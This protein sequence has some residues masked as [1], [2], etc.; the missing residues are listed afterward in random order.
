MKE[1]DEILAKTDGGLDIFVH[2]LGKECLRK[3]FRSH[4]RADDKRPSCKLYRNQALDGR[5][6]YY[7]HD[8]GDS[9]FSGDC[10]FVASQILN[11]NP[12]TDFVHLLKT[13]DQDMCLGVFDQQ[14]NRNAVR[15]ASP[16][17]SRKRLDEEKRQPHSVIAYQAQVKE[18]S[19]EELAYWSS[20]GITE[21]TLDRFQV[22]SLKSCHFTKVDGRQYDIYSTTLTPSYG[23][24][25]QEGR[26]IKVYRPHSENRFLYAGELPSPYIF[27]WDQLPRLGNMLLVTG[28]EKDVLSLSSHGFSAICFNSETAKI[29]YW[30]MDQLVKR[31]RQIVFV[32]DVDA[33]GRRESAQRVEELHGRYPVSRIDL[34]LAGSKQEKD[35]SDYFLLGGTSDSLKTLIQQT[36]NNNKR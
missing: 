1:K 4:M 15:Q 10:F 11:I 14:T 21:D 8:F 12:S 27:G 13:I 29:P 24:F 9:R 35:V 33:T 32:Y 31:F 16:M 20:Y 26:G 17:P 28:G 7:L 25:F 5:S 36:L 18:F 2:Y 34:P 3:K 22:R 23:Y 6:F 19:D 30:V